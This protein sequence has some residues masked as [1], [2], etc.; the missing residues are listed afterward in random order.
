MMNPVTSGT[1]DGFE[2]AYYTGFG[3]MELIWLL[4]TMALL[5]IAIF[6]GNKHEKSA[7]AAVEK[8]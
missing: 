3:S 1:W 2:G 8:K 6:L 7:Y 5:A 4:A